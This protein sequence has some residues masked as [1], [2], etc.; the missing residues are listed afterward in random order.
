MNELYKTEFRRVFLIRD[1]PEPLTRASSHLQIFDNYIEATRLRIR[2]IRVPETKQWTYIL[3]QR[4]AANET[5]F[6]IWKVS[7]IRLNDAEH[8]IFEQFEGRQISKNERAE[9]NEVRFNRYFYSYKNK[10][11]ALDVFLGALWGVNLAK[12]FFESEREMHELEKPDFAVAEVTNN[13]HFIGANLVGKKLSEITE[14]GKWKMEN[15]ENC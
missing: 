9:T 15:E 12:A 10:Q 3:E 1:L 4:F 11:F 6:S 2:S 13:P 5:D 14:N 8:K 7:E